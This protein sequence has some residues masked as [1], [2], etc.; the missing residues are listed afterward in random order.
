MS[1]ILLVTPS[2]RDVL[3]LAI[4]GP[5]L[6][7]QLADSGADVRW[8]IAD[9]GSGPEEVKRLSILVEVLTSIYPKIEL[10]CNEA[11]LGKGGVVRW[12]WEHCEEESWLCFLDS[13][14]SV[15]GA[16]FLDLISRAEALGQGNVIIASRKETA[17]TKVRQSGYRKLA[18][19]LFAWLARKSLRLAVYDLQCGAKCIHRLDYQAVVSRLQENGLLF[20]SELLL[21]LDS[22]GAR[23]VEQP[24]NWIEMPGGGVSPIRNAWAMV[25]GLIRLRRRLR[26]RNE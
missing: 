1:R 13:D 3:R 18:H 17:N 12:A 23:I 9:D 2:Y 25:F 21:E 11:H 4:F 15:D 5:M 24:V 16:T 20:D 6:A 19:K 8:V 7:K 10:L 22:S 26:A 14:G